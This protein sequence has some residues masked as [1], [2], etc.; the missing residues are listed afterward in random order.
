MPKKKTKSAAKQNEIN[1]LTEKH[2]RD[3]ARNMQVS[4][5]MKMNERGEGKGRDNEEGRLEFVSYVSPF[6]NKAKVLQQC[7]TMSSME[8]MFRSIRIFL[9]L[10][11]LALITACFSTS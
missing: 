2:A 5:K 9:R 6:V 3:A 8:S 10:V 11:S 4:V 7:K 1:Q